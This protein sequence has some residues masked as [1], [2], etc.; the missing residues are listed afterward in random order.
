MGINIG[1]E[2]ASKWIIRFKNYY[3]VPDKS[4]GMVEEATSH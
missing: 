1:L 2:S 4:Y 3:M